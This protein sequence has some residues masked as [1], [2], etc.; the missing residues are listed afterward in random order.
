MAVKIKNGKAIER[1]IKKAVH[2]FKNNP[3]E[4]KKSAATVQN[5][6]RRNIRAGLQVNDTPMPLLSAETINRR[7]DIVELNT[8]SKYYSKFKS[9]ATITGDFVR[10]LFAKPKGNK[11]IIEGLGT[12]KGYINSDGLIPIKSMVNISDIVRGFASRNV[13]LL[14]VT[15]NAKAKIKNQFIRFLRR[16]R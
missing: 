16:K 15:D 12:H 8:K 14:G 3:K 7:V 10:K 13:K 11:I 1:R 6:M 2:D 4:L 9:N 5:E